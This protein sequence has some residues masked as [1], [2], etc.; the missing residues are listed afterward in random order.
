MFKPGDKIKCID[1]SGWA[2]GR[3][4]EGFIYTTIHYYVMTNY[5]EHD[6][7][8]IK[9]D[10]NESCTT[11]ARRFKKVAKTVEEAYNE[12]FNDIN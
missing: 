9:D 8:F 12:G 10:N 7:V 3:L 6:T 5:P 2:T 1:D 4:T 11:Y